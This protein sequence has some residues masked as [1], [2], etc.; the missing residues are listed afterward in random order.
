[1]R[2][3]QP[4]NATVIHALENARHAKSGLTGN[5]EIDD[6]GEMAGAEVRAEAV[7]DN[8]DTGAHQHM[9][10]QQAHEGYA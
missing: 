1:M 2:T 7:V 3:R 6:D 4:A 5:C 9:V 8:G 10:D